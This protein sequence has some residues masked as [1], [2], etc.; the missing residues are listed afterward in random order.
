VSPGWNM[1]GGISE[2]VPIALITSEPPNLIVSYFF[3]YNT[4]ESRYKTTD[5]VFPGI[6][7]WIKTNQVG[8]LILKA[9]GSQKLSKAN[10]IIKPDS[11]LPPPPPQSDDK[12]QE[13]AIPKD[14]A[15]YQNYPNPFN[16]TT[17]IKYQLPLESRVTLKVYNLLG[18]VVVILAD[19][20][21]SA[22]YKS[23]EW[24][25]NSLSSCL[26]IYRLDAVSVANP[27]RSF[28]QVMKLVLIR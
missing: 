21:Q 5:T 1:I 16:P 20:V 2:P 15:L 4:D 25:A 22:G 6:G 18:Q 9:A 8:K 3:E 17:T 11:D 12:K 26:Y 23:L 13:I 28:S 24:N 19:E 10:I 14:F 7:Y 27:D